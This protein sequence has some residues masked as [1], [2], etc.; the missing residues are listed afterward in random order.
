VYRFRSA[1]ALGPGEISLPPRIF[2]PRSRVRP[3]STLDSWLSPNATLIA[4]SA[5]TA[6]N[7]QT[8]HLNLLIIRSLPCLQ[9]KR[10]RF[11][12]RFLVEH[13]SVK[14][15]HSNQRLQLGECKLCHSDVRQEIESYGCIHRICPHPLL[16]A[17]RQASDEQLEA[18]SL[19]TSLRRHFIPI[20]LRLVHDCDGH[21]L[22]LGNWMTTLLQALEKVLLP[23][24]RFD[25]V[26]SLLLDFRPLLTQRYDA[27]WEAWQEVSDLTAVSASPLGDPAP[28]HKC[29]SYRPRSRR[30]VN[31]RFYAVR[32]GRLPDIY[33]F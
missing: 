21:R 9:Y 6:P 12:R 26:R 4:N 19:A 17:A 24:D 2:S 18:Y 27:V 15:P 29:L 23:N 5:E 14:G 28:L 11:E 20:L 33:C 7:G 16:C 10:Y 8:F 1:A 22:D 25:D 30:P 31:V 13:N 32:V 3:A